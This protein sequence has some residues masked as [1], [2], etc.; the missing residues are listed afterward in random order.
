MY[1]LSHLERDNE[2]YERVK[3]IGKLLDEK[4][5][6]ESLFTV[7]LK[8]VVNNGEYFFQTHNSGHDTVK[9]PLGMFTENYIPN[10]L[11][12]VDRVVCNYFGIK[13]NQEA[14]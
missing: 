4:I 11:A 10:D 14:V 6:V 2:G 7:V 1:F 8:T 3:T 9:S 12:E 13:T 5:G